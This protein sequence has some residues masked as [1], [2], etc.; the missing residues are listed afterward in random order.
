MS[1]FALLVTIRRRV[2]LQT[3]TTQYT[4]NLLSFQGIMVIEDQTNFLLLANN[5]RDGATS[6]ND[7]TN[8]ENDENIADT[9]AQIIYA[10]VAIGLFFIGIFVLINVCPPFC[11]RMPSEMNLSWREKVREEKINRTIVGAE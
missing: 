11:R 4:N 3:P 9:H 8:N 7:F 1:L 2:T 6:D 5:S 10:V